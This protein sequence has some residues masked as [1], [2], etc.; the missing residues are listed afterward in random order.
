VRDERE[1]EPAARRRDGTRPLHRTEP[2]LALL[3]VL[4]LEALEDGAN[5]IV[6]H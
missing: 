5:A 2:A 4:A 3:L 1:Q 6:Q